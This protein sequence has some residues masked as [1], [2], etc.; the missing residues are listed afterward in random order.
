MS[1]NSQF[2]RLNNR[3]VFK[4]VSDG[5]QSLASIQR[6]SVAKDGNAEIRRQALPAGGCVEGSDSEKI[7][8]QMYN[9]R[10]G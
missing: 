10:A 2:K 7:V 1:N 3:A 9:L 5:L 8:Y 6:W 4:I